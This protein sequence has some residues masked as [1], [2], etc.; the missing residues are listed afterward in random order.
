M[1][2]CHLA[3]KV[4]MPCPK[5][6]RP[7]NIKTLKYSH[8]CGRTGDVAERAAEEEHK[9]RSEFVESLAKEFQQRPVLEPDLLKSRYSNLFSQIN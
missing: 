1:A 6:R 2:P 8:V 5:C 9:A 7:M 4:K 3:L